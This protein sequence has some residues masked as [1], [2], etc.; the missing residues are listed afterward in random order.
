MQATLHRFTLERIEADAWRGGLYESSRMEVMA[1]HD[2]VTFPTHLQD[3]SVFVRTLD[4]LGE[5]ADDD[6]KA[7]LG[8][9]REAA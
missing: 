8:E 3:V 1:S 7:I 4:L 2:F 9:L 6:R 5:Y